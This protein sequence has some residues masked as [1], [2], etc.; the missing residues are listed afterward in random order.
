VYYQN[1]LHCVF[2]EHSVNVSYSRLVFPLA[3]LDSPESVIFV[4]SLSS[5]SSLSFWRQCFRVCVVWIFPKMPVLIKPRS[6]P[7][8][9]FNFS[10][11]VS[12]AMHSFQVCLPLPLLFHSNWLIT[13]NYIPTV[14]RVCPNC[15]CLAYWHYIRSPPWI[16]CLFSACIYI[17][18]NT[19]MRNL[20]LIHV[21][22]EAF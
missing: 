12:S 8:S 2:K 3:L 4:C 9:L 6:C 11:L 19:M 15:S 21:Y 14:Y 13:T 16:F 5:S 17:L 7:S 10:I 18:Y 22:P 1:L 20:R